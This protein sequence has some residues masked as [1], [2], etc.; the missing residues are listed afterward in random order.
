MQVDADLEPAEPHHAQPQHQLPANEGVIQQAPL[1]PAAPGMPAPLRLYYIAGFEFECPQRYTVDRVIGRGA[2]GMVCAAIDHVRREMV[3]IKRINGVTHDVTDCKRTLREMLLLRHFGDEHIVTLKDVYLPTRDLPNFQEV[4][5][6]T[7]LME[8]DLHQLITSNQPISA[9]HT[10]YLAYQ[11]LQG[12]KYIHSAGVLHRDLK[13]SNILL[14]QRCQLKICDFGLARD[15][16]RNEAMQDQMTAYVATRWY[17]APEILLGGRYSE[18]VDVWSVGCILAEIVLRRP[19]FPG[20]TCHQQMITVAH[21]IGPPPQSMVLDLCTRPAQVFVDKYLRHLPTRNVRDLFPHAPDA[22]RDI[23]ALMLEYDPR[24]RI[25][26]LQAFQH[27]Y[28]LALHDVADEPICERKFSGNLDSFALP[29]LA[30]MIWRESELYRAR[31]EAED[32]EAQ[33]DPMA[34]T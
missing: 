23:L 4:Y 18:A 12:L 24:K 1:H 15:A 7:D 14:D 9:D 31:R 17:R 13:P 25:T 2:Y 21:T 32:R 27:P 29:H 16:P 6:V 28:L 33:L 34:L 3:A 8:F 22:L 5:F 10:K 20:T 11:L 19:L 30:Q 26:V